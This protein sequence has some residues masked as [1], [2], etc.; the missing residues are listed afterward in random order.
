[1]QIQVPVQEPK[2]VIAAMKEDGHRRA[3]QGSPEHV[4][5]IDCECVDDEILFAAGHLK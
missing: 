4:R 5:R 1:M 2:I 3:L